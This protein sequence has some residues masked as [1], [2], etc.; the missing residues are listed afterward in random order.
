MELLYETNIDN[1][2]IKYYDLG[3]NGKASNYFAN[4]GH[5]KCNTRILKVSYWY[6]T[7]YNELRQLENR[8]YEEKIWYYGRVGGEYDRDWAANKYRSTLD[9]KII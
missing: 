3:D 2:S 1:G 4:N 7:V 9:Y 6:H 8:R 5:H